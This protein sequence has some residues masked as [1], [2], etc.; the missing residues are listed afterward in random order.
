MTELALRIID[1]NINKSDI[2]CAQDQDF[3]ACDD[4]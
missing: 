1:T 3:I 4:Q 2:W